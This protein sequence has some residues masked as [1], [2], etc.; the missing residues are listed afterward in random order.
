[1]HKYNLIIFIIS[2]LYFSNNILS[3]EIK[4]KKIQMGVILGNNLNII[5][6][7][8][9]IMKTNNPGYDFTI[10]VNLIKNFNK[11]LGFNSGIEFDFSS[12][13]YTFQDTLYYDFKDNLI[14]S[15]NEI[16][17]TENYNRFC[18]KERTQKPIY[19][20]IPTMLIFKTDF[21]GYNR[22]F[23]KFGMR[24]NF[25]LKE[26]TNDTGILDSINERMKLN[27]D[28]A[29]YS[30]SI[31][32]SAGTEWNYIGSSSMLFEIGYYYGISNLH[33]ENAIIGEQDKNKTLYI[34]DKSNDKNYQTLHSSRNQIAF[35]I[36][37]LF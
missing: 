9:K 12:S 34:L 36:S 6:S 15:K 31:G 23:A 22:Y 8:T 35:K 30:G 4:D 11:N 19:L 26:T 33:R 7:D 17:N 10:G 32:I 14:L 13:T 28:L 20:S 21:I 18:L 2:F 3:Q 24:H 29:I 16:N 37:F 1:M 25:T 5:T 27:K